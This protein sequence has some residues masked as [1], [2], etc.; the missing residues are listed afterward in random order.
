MK[1]RRLLFWVKDPYSDSSDELFT[2]AEKKISATAFPIATTTAEYAK[3]SVYP[4]PRMRPDF[5]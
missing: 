3:I 2:K 1:Y 4:L 5:P